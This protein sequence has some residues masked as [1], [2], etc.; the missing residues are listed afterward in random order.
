MNIKTLGAAILAGVVVAG[1][2]QKTTDGDKKAEAD[3][4]AVTVNG[5]TLMKSKIA[6]DVDTIIKAQG[7]KI[8]ETQRAYA[9]QMAENQLVQHAENRH[10]RTAAFSIR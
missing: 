9:R 8:P 4:A 5:K 10:C 1:C 6:A 7:D 2:D 3:S